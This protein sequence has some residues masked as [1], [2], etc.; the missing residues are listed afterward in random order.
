MLQQTELKDVC[1]MFIAAMTQF[2][3]HILWV[4]EMSVCVQVSEKLFNRMVDAAKD[5][6]VVKQARKT[7]TLVSVELRPNAV[8][9]DTDLLKDDAKEAQKSNTADRPFKLDE[10]R[11]LRSQPSSDEVDKWWNKI[12]Q[13]N[14]TKGKVFAAENF[15]RC[16]HFDKIC[17]TFP[18]ANTCILA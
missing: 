4:L 10:L 8:P 12:I 5:L 1:F 9:V 3:Q 13:L 18:P 14:A 7:E 15:L 6:A 17:T 16:L 2:Y 11:K